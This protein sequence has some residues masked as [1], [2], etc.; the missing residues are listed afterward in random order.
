MALILPIL[1]AAVIYFLFI[2]P[3]QRQVRQH[4]ELVSHL[5]V[6]D[7]IITSAGIYGSIT[8]LD[9]ETMSVEVA[10][11]VV[12]TM[13]RRAVAEVAVDEVD[14]DDDADGADDAPRNTDLDG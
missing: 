11:G 10:D 12:L 14:E 3:Q 5:E 8:A 9:D 13:A 1:F 7:E 6:G 4:Q 2:R